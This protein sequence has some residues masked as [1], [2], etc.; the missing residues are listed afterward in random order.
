MSKTKKL[1]I[2]L[3]NS[4]SITKASMEDTLRPLERVLYIHHPF[5]FQK[6]LYK[7]KTLINL[8]NEINTIIPAY[9]L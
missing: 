3:A 8:S 7:A 9:T 4:S 2:V 5:Y 6:D 1:A